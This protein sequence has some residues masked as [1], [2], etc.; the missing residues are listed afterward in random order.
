MLGKVLEEVGVFAQPITKIS[1]TTIGEF[2]GFAEILDTRLAKP[3]YDYFNDAVDPPDSQGVLLALN[4]SPKDHDNLDVV[5]DD[6][7]GG[8]T[9]GGG[10]LQFD[11]Q[12][13]ATSNGDVCAESTETA[14]SESFERKESVTA[15]SAD[16]KL[17]C[18]FCLD[19]DKSDEF[20]FV[21]RGFDVA[22]TTGSDATDP[23][24]DTGQEPVPAS[25][26]DVDGPVVQISVQFDDTIIEDGRIV[27]AELEAITSETAEDFVELETTGALVL[28]Y[29]STNPEI[30]PP[31]KTG[32]SEPDQ[33][34]NDSQ[35]IV[36][37][38]FTA[39]IGE[40]K[41]LVI[42]KAQVN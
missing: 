39:D 21:F 22:L 20:F 3:V 16:L 11:L 2:I 5:I 34:Q 24:E 19:V 27:L 8:L 25:T 42:K 26:G 41:N 10:A 28:L 37:S 23:K 18:S 35:N 38:N 6:L 40:I 12:I 7:D 29:A 30:D 32:A 1:D 15:I 17:D 4:K 31:E 36:P 9:P 13:R 33:G 14:T